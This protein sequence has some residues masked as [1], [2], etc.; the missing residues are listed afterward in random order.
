[1]S[2]PVYIVIIDYSGRRTFYYSTEFSLG[3]DEVVVVVERI[4]RRREQRSNEDSVPE[5]VQGASP[6][7]VDPGVR[8]DSSDNV[9][10]GTAPREKVLM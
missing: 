2:V 10:G 8:E 6:R 4:R 9:E 1:M 7:F 3:V 5:G